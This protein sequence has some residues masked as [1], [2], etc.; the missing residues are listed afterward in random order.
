MNGYV[1]T[2]I[3]TV[4][5]CSLA[6]M[7]TPE[8][9][10]MLGYVKL[11]AGLCVLC[12]AIAPLTS[13]IGAVMNFELGDGFFGDGSGDENNFGQI[14]EESLLGAGQSSASE[15]LRVMICREFGLSA[16]DIQVNVKLNDEGEEYLPESVTVVLVGGK[17]ILTDPHDVINYVTELLG[18]RCEIIYG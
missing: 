17:A 4:I 18:C 8:E 3:G 14:Y 13:F 1:T 16:D 12:V 15:G 6:A 2:L 7:L 9:N 10:G 11:A 5:I